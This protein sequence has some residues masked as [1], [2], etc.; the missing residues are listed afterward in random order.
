M[1]PYRE[2]DKAFIIYPITELSNV[3]NSYN[4]CIAPITYD[5]S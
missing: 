3:L 5:Y 2:N 1:P 4:T